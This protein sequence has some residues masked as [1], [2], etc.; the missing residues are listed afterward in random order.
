M[1]AVT[2]G[3]AASA[4]V[5]SKRAVKEKGLFTMLFEAIAAAQMKKAEREIARY[6]YLLPR[7]GDGDES[8][9]FGGR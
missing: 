9:P 4:V 6:R 3:V 8:L 5:D 1:V 2:Y 7:A